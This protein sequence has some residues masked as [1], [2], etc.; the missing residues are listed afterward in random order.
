MFNNLPHFDMSPILSQLGLESDPRGGNRTRT[1]PSESG[2]DWSLF[3]NELFFFIRERKTCGS[4]VTRCNNSKII[5][6]KDSHG[7]LGS[8]CCEFRNILLFIF[9]CIEE[10]AKQGEHP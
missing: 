5:F 3:A 7:D 4:L 9:F 6:C 10:G 2:S 1:L 8:G